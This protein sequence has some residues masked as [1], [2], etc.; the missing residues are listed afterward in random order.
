MKEDWRGEKEK[1][2]G[3]RNKGKVRKET[4]KM[5]GCGENRAERQGGERRRRWERDRKEGRKRQREERDP[6]QPYNEACCY[7]A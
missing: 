4:G 5:E 3:R 1:H 7:L 2:R 6:N